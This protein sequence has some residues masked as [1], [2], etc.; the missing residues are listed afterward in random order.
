MRFVFL[1]VIVVPPRQLERIALAAQRRRGG[2]G[3][4]RRQARPGVDEGLS[5]SRDGATGRGTKRD[6]L[7]PLGRGQRIE[8]CAHGADAVVDPAL[9]THHVEVKDVPPEWLHGHSTHLFNTEQDIDRLVAAP[10][11]EL[12]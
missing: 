8:S 3:D 1:E 2:V 6:Q 10:R 9:D 4:H 5:I 7:S 12:A 11:A